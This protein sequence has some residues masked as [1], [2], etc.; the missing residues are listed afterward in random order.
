MVTEEKPKEGFEMEVLA[1]EDIKM[2]EAIEDSLRVLLRRASLSLKLLQ[3]PEQVVHRHR[4]IL[5]VAL[6]RFLHILRR[7]R[8]LQP[9][10]PP[11]A[12]AHLKVLLRGPLHVC[13]RGLLMRV[14]SLGHLYKHEECIAWIGKGR[15]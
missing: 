15:I 6:E 10:H 8:R 7:L 1:L 9:E 5:R 4:P 3:E 14:W 13:F 2:L 12:E 11:A